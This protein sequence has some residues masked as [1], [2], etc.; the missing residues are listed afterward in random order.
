MRMYPP[1]PTYGREA[2]VPVELGGYTLNS[3][4]VIL[5]SPHIFHMDARWWRNPEEFR[6]ERFS[7]ENE[8]LIP[9]YAYLPFGGGPRICIGNSFAQMESVLLLAT[10]AHQYRLRL[11]P[12]DQPVTPEPTLTLRPR[13][14][15]TMRLEKREPVQDQE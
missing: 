11:D 9:K 4:S 7:K 5:I 2:K 8:K 6:P 13:H 15:L 12:A 1:I 14:N 3:G 10:I